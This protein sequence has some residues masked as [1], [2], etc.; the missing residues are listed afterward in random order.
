MKAITLCYG[1]YSSKVSPLL[2]KVKNNL[3]L[4]LTAY[5]ILN[6]LCSETHFLSIP[7]QHKAF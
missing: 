2:C 5:K 4:F 1:N 7:S 6:S 3:I